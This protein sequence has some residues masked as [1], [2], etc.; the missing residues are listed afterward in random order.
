M[1]KRMLTAVDSECRSIN[2]RQGL[3]LAGEIPLALPELEHELDML[4]RQRL[5]LD[6]GV[7]GPQA[8]AE[9]AAA[10]VE[11]DR[12]RV[13]RARIRILRHDFHPPVTGS[14]P[15]DRE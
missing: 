2:R 13:S 7:G 9:I 15:C 12:R 6:M 3:A 11:V 5:R 14:G 4:V 10:D 8:R 1:I